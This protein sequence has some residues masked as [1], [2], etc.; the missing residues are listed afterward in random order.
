MTNDWIHDNYIVKSIISVIGWEFG[1]A[2]IAT[3]LVSIFQVLPR[4]ALNQHT[5][6]SIDADLPVDH[7]TANRFIPSIN[8]VY[9]VYWIYIILLTIICLTMSTLKGYFQKIGDETLFNLFQTLLATALGVSEALGAVCFIKYGRLV[10]K[11]INESATLVGLMDNRNSGNKNR[12]LESY[13][14]HLKKLKIMNL[15][16]SILVCWLGFLGFCVAITRIMVEKYT[17]LYITIAAISIDGTAIIMLITLLGIVYGEM[18][19][20]RSIQAEEITTSIN[21]S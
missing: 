6:Y 16:L 1:L 12:Y 7:L 21:Y 19:K 18:Y 9:K 17:P 14:I 5:I 20:Q 8:S 4:L 15:S 2:A 13:R 3:Y 11:L 10:V